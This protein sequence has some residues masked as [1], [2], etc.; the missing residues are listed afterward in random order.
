MAQIYLPNGLGNPTRYAIE[1]AATITATERLGEEYTASD[2]KS[3]RDF[4]ASSLSVIGATPAG[5]GLRLIEE[6]IEKLA[7]DRG[8][9]LR[10]N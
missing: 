1:K 5:I 6:E 2:L 3:A 8:K 4:V 9:T 10:K 7:K